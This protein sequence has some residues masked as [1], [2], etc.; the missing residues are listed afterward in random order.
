MKPAKL[1]AATLMLTSSCLA[2][3]PASKT[4]GLAQSRKTLSLTRMLPVRDSRFSPLA[5]GCTIFLPPRLISGAATIRGK[6]SRTVLVDLVVLGNGQID[7]PFI[8]EG[9]DA[10]LDEQLQE[11]LSQWRYQPAM[12]DGTP[13]D[14]E[15]RIHLKLESEVAPPKPELQFPH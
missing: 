9:G 14:A 4:V 1:I 11:I 15:G 12:C 13:I 3:I 2:D 5:S 7:A 10:S 8:I 6:N